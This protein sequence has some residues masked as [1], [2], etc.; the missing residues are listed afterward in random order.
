MHCGVDKRAFAMLYVSAP[1]NPR[2][3]TTRTRSKTYELV[4]P[5][6]PCMLAFVVMLFHETNDGTQFLGSGVLDVSQLKQ[7][8]LNVSI[9]DASTRPHTHVGFVTL[10]FLHV[11]DIPCHLTIQSPQ[12][13]RATFDA[14]EA[15]LTW[16][17]GFGARGLP[18]IANS[19][20]KLIHSPYYVNHL[21]VTLP[22]GAFC[23]IPTSLVGSAERAIASH[24]ERLMICLE[25][26]FIRPDIFVQRVSRIVSG[27]IKSKHLKCLMVVADMLTI[28]TRIAVKYV[29]DSVYSDDPKGTERWEMPREPTLTNGQTSF[30]G[31]CEDFAREVY[32]HAKE[33][34]AWVI[35]ALHK[36]PMEALSAILHMY[37]PTI[38]QGA[39]DKNAV[40]DLQRKI[41][42]NV[43][44][45]NHI[46]AALH[47]RHSFRT[48]ILGTKCSL[49]AL[50]AKW[51]VQPCE[52]KLPIIMLEGTGDVYPIVTA[53]DTTPEF[54]IRMQQ[55]KEHMESLYP[56]LKDMESPDMSIQLCQT[57]DFYKYAIACMTDVFSDQGFLD[58]TYVTHHHYGVD[59]YDWARGKYRLRI[60][61]E[62]SSD[63]MQYIHELID[64]ERPI[65]P[66]ETTSCTMQQPCVTSEY[67]VRF[68]QSTPISDIPIGS[69][70]GTYKLS[71]KTWYELYFPIV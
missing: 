20:L 62:I 16:I 31:D 3:I 5:Q 43:D 49:D 71:D 42:P 14:A 68:G 4:M 32:Q 21:G 34:A 54:M 63:V 64:I 36:S 2:Y 59:M 50:Y 67:A 58:F 10:S 45:R 53:T 6:S 24:R 52:Q 56:F 70:L 33:I 26:N 30:I 69:T 17:Q 19:R 47:P 66:I 15:N 18:P 55:K 40:S 48:K 23:M 8:S 9:Y 46:W 41:M 22:S 57:S 35:P 7:T 39:V 51:P 25:R 1:S 28:H 44:Y 12:V 13:V 27:A 65:D 37:V 11:P 29:P 60:S 38:E 61:N